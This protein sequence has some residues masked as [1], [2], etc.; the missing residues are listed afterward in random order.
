MFFFDE[1]FQSPRQVPQV[2]VFLAF[3]SWRSLVA[4]AIAASSSATAFVNS[5][6]SSVSL[7]MEASNL[8]SCWWAWRWRSQDPSRKLSRVRGILSGPGITQHISN[9]V[10]ENVVN[11]S[12]RFAK[13]IYLIWDF[14]TT[15]LKK[16]LDRNWSQW[17]FSGCPDPSWTANW[18]SNYIFERPSV[19]N[20]GKSDSPTYWQYGSLRD[21]TP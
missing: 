9:F 1:P 20:P 10:P 7:A 13:V 6:I 11:F 5:L 18:I 19:E 15:V 2:S 8:G 4:F 14:Y 21:M 16:H 12:N 3:S 17:P